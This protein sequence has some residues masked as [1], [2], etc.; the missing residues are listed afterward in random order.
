MAAHSDVHRCVH[1]YTTYTFEKKIYIYIYIIYI[2]MLPPPQRST[3]FFLYFCFC[4][5]H[6][7]ISAMAQRK[8][9]QEFL[10]VLES[11]NL[12]GKGM[13]EA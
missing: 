7:Q 2:Y 3:C 9:E 12:A 10:Q 11:D 6:W 8:R 13:S 1:N 5:Q 4:R